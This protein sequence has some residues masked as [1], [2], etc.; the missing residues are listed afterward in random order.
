MQFR[1]TTLGTM[2]DLDAIGQALREADPSALL[3]VG[4]NAD[5]LRISTC[6]SMYELI[7][8][9][10]GAGYVMACEQVTAL[11]SECC[12]ACG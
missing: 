4:R 1:V 7:D 2:P 9:L 10:Q 8:V 11:A 3:D 6:M 12:G 5:H